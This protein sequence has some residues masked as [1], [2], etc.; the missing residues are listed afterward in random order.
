[1]TRNPVADRPLTS[2]AV[3]EIF[4]VSPD[5]VCR[6]AE[7]GKLKFFRTPGGHFRFQRAD[8]DA[9]LAEQAST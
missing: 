6:W 1:M 4:G 2:G 5:T 7:A 9:F 8:V 3:A